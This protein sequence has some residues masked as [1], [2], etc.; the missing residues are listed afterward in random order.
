MDPITLIIITLISG[1][2]GWIVGTR[3]GEEDNRRAGL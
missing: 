3:I 2:S 1:A